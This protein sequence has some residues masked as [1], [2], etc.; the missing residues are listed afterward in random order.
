MLCILC[1]SSHS[2][3]QKVS[4]NIIKYSTNRTIIIVN[5]SREI[6]LFAAGSLVAVRPTMYCELSDVY[7]LA[8]A[9]CPGL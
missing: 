5:I 9:V 1:E 3:L 4:Q 8:T 6:M 2:W 7:Q